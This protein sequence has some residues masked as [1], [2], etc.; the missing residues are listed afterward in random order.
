MHPCGAT[1]VRPAWR[2]STASP[3]CR[4]ATNNGGLARTDGGEKPETTLLGI[5]LDDGRRMIA[6]RNRPEKGCREMMSSFVWLLL[7][8]RYH[9]RKSFVQGPE[10]VV[11]ANPS[12]GQVCLQHFAHG[13]RLASQAPR[14]CDARL[15]FRVWLMAWS[16]WRICGVGGGGQGGAAAAQSAKSQTSAAALSAQ[17]MRMGRAFMRPFG[18]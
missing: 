5:V 7:F 2:Q 15:H 13:P 6:R 8:G 12:A 17:Q 1:T 3:P 10:V 4:C 16:R 9:D 11:P 14:N 18:R